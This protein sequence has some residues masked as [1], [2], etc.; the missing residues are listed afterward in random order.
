MSP[1]PC[2]R[3]RDAVAGEP[4]CVDAALD[5]VSV[6]RELSRRGLTE[7]L[8]R[9]GARLGLFTGADLRDALLRAEPPSRLAVGEVACFAP[10]GVQA[11]SA[12][13]GTLGL[14]QRHRV[15]HLV[16]RDG[17]RVLGVLG[18]ADLAGF[19]ARHSPLAA[20]QIDAA[21][22]LAALRSATAHVDDTVASLH[23]AGIK[24]ERIAG[25]VSEL[26]A[27]LFARLWA[28]L[29]PADLVANS[30]LLVM[31]S[32]GRGEQIVKTDQDNALLLRDGFECADLQAVAGR[33]NDALAGLG[34][35]PC[36]G[37]IMLINPLWRQPL[38]GFRESL[39][40]WVH[41][42]DPEGP[43]R[44]AIFIDAAPV[45][46]DA[47]LLHDAHAHLDRILV[48]SDAF[49]A[50]FAAAADRFDEPGPW[51]GRLIARRDDQPLDLKKL[52]IFPIVH[53]LRALAL[54]HGLHATASAERARLLAEGRH[55]DADLARDAV[56]ALHALTALRLG[57]QLRQRRE[58]LAP[59]NLVRP[60]ALATLERNQLLGA[61]AIVKRLREFLRSHFRLDSL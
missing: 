28:L 29:A 55:L 45:A 6:C 21:D 26:N 2:A 34:W 42:H 51:W 40:D 50:R 13:F 5:L 38:A 4:F 9:D 3:V 54:Q 16:V 15:R 43:M 27:R 37:G 30:C 36:P 52:G 1:L 44:L 46:G 60:S 25:W 53:G 14:M 24:V 32:E 10:V 35:P 47:R 22:S 39:L 17:D 11:D 49:L 12:L 59:G 61:L 18:Q 20:P 23:D 58:G 48:D 33:F 41:G 19:M 56:D 57:D 31:G 8:V 7:A